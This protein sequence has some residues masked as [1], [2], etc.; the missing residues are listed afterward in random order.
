MWLCSE[1]RQEIIQIKYWRKNVI[2]TLVAVGSQRICS[3]DNSENRWLNKEK[4]DLR[5]F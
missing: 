4:E 5:M 2:V 3:S 1:K